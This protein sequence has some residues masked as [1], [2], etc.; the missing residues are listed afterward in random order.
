[1]PVYL[2]VLFMFHFYFGVMGIIAAIVLIALTVWNE[3]STRGDLQEA[4]RES[5]LAQQLAQSNL[6][7][8]EVV[9]AMGML[10]RMRERWQA[11]QKWRCWPCKAVPAASPA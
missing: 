6:R 10:P 2:A 8:A 7:N 11:R 1:M 5:V 4:N 3:N 9:E